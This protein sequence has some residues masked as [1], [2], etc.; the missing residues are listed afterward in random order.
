MHVEYKDWI[1][2][3]TCNHCSKYLNSFLYCDLFLFVTIIYVCIHEYINEL[4]GICLCEIL[5]GLY[6]NKKQHKNIARVWIVLNFIELSWW[7]TLLSLLPHKK[8]IISRVLTESFLIFS[9][10]Q[11]YKMSRPP[12]NWYKTSFD[13]FVIRHRPQY[14]SMCPFYIKLTRTQKS[15]SKLGGELTSSGISSKLVRW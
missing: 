4:M 15:T 1:K 2:T 6:T 5:L 3:L 9:N 12:L 14:E 8:K 11:T 7:E 13:S 10:I